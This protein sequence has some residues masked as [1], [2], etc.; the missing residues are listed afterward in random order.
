M[1]LDLGL[2]LGL[3]LDNTSYEPKLTNVFFTHNQSVLLDDILSAGG[4]LQLYNYNLTIVAE[5]EVESKLPFIFVTCAIYNVS[6]VS[7]ATVPRS[8]NV[9]CKVCLLFVKSFRPRYY[10]P[11]NRHY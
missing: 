5:L 10:H 4:D 1:N 11:K 6:A 2:G 3:W 7:P 9:F 8:L